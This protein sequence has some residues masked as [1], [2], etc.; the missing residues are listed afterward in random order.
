MGFRH[1]SYNKTKLSMTLKIFTST[2]ACLL[3]CSSSLWS[4]D[5]VVRP[6]KGELRKAIERAK[7]GDRILLKSGTYEIDSTLVLQ[8]VNNISIEPYR[9]N[10]KVIISGGRTLPRRL[11]KRM[12]RSE[13][14]ALGLQKGVRA[15]DISS[16]PN[17]VPPGEAGFNHNLRTGWTQLF[18]GDRVFQ[19]S[20]WPDEGYL[21]TDSVICAG[22][23]ITKNKHLTSLGKISIKERRPLEWRHPR[24]VVMRGYFDAGWCEEFLGIASIDSNMVISCADTSTYGFAKGED[25]QR[26]CMHNIAEEVNSPGEYAVDMEDARIYAILPRGFKR[27]VISNLDETL[28]KISG[29]SNVTISGISFMY[30]RHDGV[31]VEECEAVVMEDCRFCNL[32]RVAVTIDASSLSCG[33]RR[34]EIFNIASGGV[35]LDG[36]DR[37]ALKKG[38]NFVEHC[39]IY[40]YNMF[41]T[42]YRP[43]VFVK[44]MGNR[45]SHC[46]IHSSAA[47][48]I[49]MHGN[50]QVIEYCDIYDV[51]REIEDNGAIYYGRNPTERGNVIRYNYFH[52]LQSQF[53]IRAVYHD[54][55]A[56]S[57]EVYGNIFHNVST[58]PVQIGGGSDI[59]Y[60]DN[61][62]LNLPTTAIKI[63]ARIQTWAAW[64]VPDYKKKVAAM[65]GPEFRAYYPEFASYWEGDFSTP[66]RNV[67]ERNVFYNVKNVFERVHWDQHD[68]NDI[69]IGEANYVSRMNDNWV[70]SENPGFVDTNDP[71]KGFVSSPALLEHIPDFKLD[72][73]FFDKI[74]PR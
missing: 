8:G 37:K 29:C 55:G 2:L 58:A 20:R 65:D 51:C 60:H 5:I 73:D 6:R 10:S 47:Q 7:D 59:V 3:V 68:F 26:W 43:G 69:V 9:K 38:E 31:S 33:L 61:I 56:C 63:D 11:F 46:R 18:L 34:A 66:S 45:V 44:G 52:D 53:N 62:F 48:A 49:L 23:A 74:G 70:C 16:M 13:R 28:L 64:M 36:G 19:L 35:V 1:S 32:G 15:L 27:P 39:H 24:Q 4:A 12:S 25:H 42:S 72:R 71:S 40:D 21:R 57:C 17:I 67:L 50:E 14:S 54:D 41:V 30:G 22:R